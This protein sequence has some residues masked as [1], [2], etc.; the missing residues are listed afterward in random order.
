MISSERKSKTAAPPETNDLIALTNHCAPCRDKIADRLLDLGAGQLFAE[1]ERVEPAASVF[2][3]ER[4][5]LFDGKGLKAHRIARQPLSECHELAGQDRRD[6]DQNDN[7]DRD[8]DHE[9]EQSRAQPIEPE[10]LQFADDRVEEIPERDSGGERRHDRAEHM[11]G[12]AE[13]R[14]HDG[15][16]QDLTFDAHFAELVCSA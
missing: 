9:N 14:E 2:R 11:Q 16:E 7:E 5:A 6:D 8:E 12:V 15:P 10:P 13:H 4:I 1:P 3:D